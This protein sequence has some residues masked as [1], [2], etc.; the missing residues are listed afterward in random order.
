[1]TLISVLVL[2]LNQIPELLVNDLL[3]SGI[4]PSMIY[5]LF[6][7]YKVHQF[8]LEATN[9]FIIFTGILELVVLI[10]AIITD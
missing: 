5:E 10:I 8:M 3:N 2:L 6:P 7:E 1:M 4:V 9:G